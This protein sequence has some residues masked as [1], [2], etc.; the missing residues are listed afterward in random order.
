MAEMKR[1]IEGADDQGGT[2]RATADPA[3]LGDIVG[4]FLSEKS[5]G[6][7]DGKINLGHKSSGFSTGFRDGLTDF[8]ANSLGQLFLVGVKYF[9]GRAQ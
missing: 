5:F 9:L 7:P 8:T 1:K 2:A 4:G 6:V 3:G